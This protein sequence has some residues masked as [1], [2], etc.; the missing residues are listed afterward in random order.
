MPR[1]QVA[2][3]RRQ[4]NKNMACGR[5]TKGT[6]GALPGSSYH[7][8]RSYRKDAEILKTKIAREL[9]HKGRAYV[10]EYHFTEYE[11][12]SIRRISDGGAEG[13]NQDGVPLIDPQLLKE[14]IHRLVVTIS[15]E[16]AHQSQ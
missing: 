7:T 8:K 15:V 11:G 16:M 13:R 4:F 2:K 5:P 10:I 14:V 12:L 9:V 1:G 3:C 6:Q